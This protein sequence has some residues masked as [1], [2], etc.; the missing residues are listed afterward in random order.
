MRDRVVRAPGERDARV[1]H[2][3]KRHDLDRLWRW[4]F[5]QSVTEVVE[6]ERLYDRDGPG[7]GDPAHE[8]WVDDKRVLEPRP[9]WKAI[10]NARRPLDRG[11]PDRDRL[12]SNGVLG[13]LKSSLGC[14]AHGRI[15]RVLV[16]E[17]DS[18]VQE[19]IRTPAQP[20]ASTRR[21][22]RRKPGAADRAADRDR[23]C[24]HNLAYG[25]AERAPLC[26]V[27]KELRRADRSDCG[28]RTRRVVV[29]SR[30]EHARRPHR[31]P[32]DGH[33]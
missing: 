31:H 1:E 26:A 4:N 8:R 18:L 7:V 32:M 17:Q 20:R 30:R 33:G 19:P 25:D 24:A 13:N 6:I 21:A 11:Q 2:S 15:E 27:E 29:E 5:G 3:P 16:P 10:Q 22:D 9:A 28:P 14:R 23:R 12:V